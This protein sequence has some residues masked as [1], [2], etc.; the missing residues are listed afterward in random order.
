MRILHLIDS[1]QGG[2]AERQLGYIGVGLVQ[3]GHEVHVGHL[4]DGPFAARLKSGGVQLHRLGWHNAFDPTQLPPLVR[5]IRDTRADVVQTWLRRM[6]F[7]GGA[8]ACLSMRPWI[9][10]ER[11]NGGD[12]HDL[13]ERLR[14]HWSAYADRIVTNSEAAAESWRLRAGNRVRFVRNALPLDEIAAAPPATRAGLGFEPDAEVILFPGGFAPAKDPLLFAAALD[15]VLR[16]RPHAVALVCGDGELAGAFAERMA[17]HVSTGRCRLLGFRADYWS[18]LKCADVAISTSARE[19]EPNA[20]LEAM[21]C[22]CPLVLS[23]IVPHRTLATGGAARLFAAGSAEAAARAL[24]YALDNPAD[25][26]RRAQRARAMVR[27]RDLL[28]T[29]RAWEAVYAEVLS[30][31]ARRAA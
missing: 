17:W 25:T 20:V 3:L 29:A 13:R 18:L 8:A 5:L 22:R 27:D 30:A 24:Q 15:H 31:D 10:A 2:G 14:R 11:S 6:D 26:R 28:S 21:A 1:L 9:Y 4:L 16:R 7:A 23:D 12:H 19:G